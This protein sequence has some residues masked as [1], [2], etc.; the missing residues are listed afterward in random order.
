[1]G[2]RRLRQPAPSPNISSNVARARVGQRP[3]KGHVWEAPLTTDKKIIKRRQFLKGATVAGVAAAAST[4]L[5]APAIAQGR[6][7]WR[8]GTSWPKGMGGVQTGAERLAANIARMTDGK[9]TIRVFS[10][11]EV[12]PALQGVD[13]VSA[14]TLDCYHDASYYHIG[15]NPAFQFFTCVPFGFTANE[16]SAWINHGGGQA[17]WDKFYSNYNL[18][19]FIAGNTGTQA[20]G[21]YRNEIKSVDDYKGKKLRMPGWGGA[22]LARLGAQQVVVPG[23]EIFAALQSGAIDGGEWI[24]PYN[25]LALGFYQVAK[26][27]Y[28]PGFH[29]PGSA[30]QFMA[31]KGKWDALPNDIKAAVQVAC[32]W[33]HDDMWAEYTMRSGEAMETLRTRHG[34]RFLRT[35]RN[36][37][38]AFGDAAGKYL[39]EVREK[40]DPMTKEI[41]ASYLKAR[42]QLLPYSRFAEGAYLEARNLAFKYI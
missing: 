29:E 4:T 33:A 42:S 19:A 10:A 11:G 36:V 7:E 27:C 21:W 24:G 13:A 8:M 23:G 31:N 26:I 35:P 22:I 37:L 5:S 9:L 16:M 2:A 17:L 40:A 28:G 12:V 18:K 38:V 41:F 25:D 14:G 1:M 39:G 20:L 3:A 6:M 30:L 34:V 32:G 15:K